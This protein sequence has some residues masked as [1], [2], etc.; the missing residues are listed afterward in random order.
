MAAVL[1]SI[2]YTLYSA[3]LL[4]AK[5]QASQI[6]DWTTTNQEISH[7]G[8]GDIKQKYARQDQILP[9]LLKFLL[10][11][12]CNVVN[13]VKIGLDQF[14]SLAV[15]TLDKGLARAASYITCTSIYLVS[16]HMAQ[17]HTTAPI[18]RQEML[19]W[20]INI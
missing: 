8:E 19:P 20:D 5:H 16:A 10:F 4:Y 6:P 1:W 7:I 18:M 14:F 11:L 15:P 9:K 13:L 17:L 3:R 2:K 12:I